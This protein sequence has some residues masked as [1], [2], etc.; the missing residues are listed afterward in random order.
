VEGR[1][2][3][4]VV[5]DFNINIIKA[6]KETTPR[7]VREKKYTPYWTETPQ[8]AHD[9]MTKAREEAETS[10]EDHNNLSKSKA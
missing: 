2:I 1:N 5:N 8:D 10:Q 7:G 6:A 3:N 4:K 9:K